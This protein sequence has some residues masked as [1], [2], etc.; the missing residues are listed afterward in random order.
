MRVLSSY[1]ILLLLGFVIFP[2]K[3][4]VADK[5]V[6][7]MVF[8]D[9][10]LSLD[11]RVQDLISRLSLEE[12]IAQMMN[13]TPEIKRLNIPAYNY[14]NEALHG[15]GRSGVATVFPQAIGLGATFDADL[16]LR[17]SSA[18]SDEARAMYN[19]AKAK[20][21]NLQYGGLTFWTPNINIFRDPRWGRGQETYGEDPFLTAKIGTA[22]VQGLQGD[23]PNYLKTAACAKHFAVHSGPEKVRHGFNAEATPKDLWETFLPAFQALVVDAKVE[24]VMC[25][26][27]STNGEPCCA[28]K[29]LIT[30]VLK[31]QWGF[32]GH[33]VTDCGAIQDFYTTKEKGG[34]GT[35]ETKAQAAALVLKSGV[36]L[37]CGDSF[38]ALGDAVKQGLLTE[39]DIDKELAVLLRTRF[40]LGL[41]DPMGSNPYDAI[42][43]TV[44][45]SSEHRALAKEVAQKSM[46]LLKN[47]GVLPLKNDL[48]K[49]FVTGPNASSIEVLLGNYY[50]INPDMVTILEGI[51]GAIQPESKLEYRLGAMLN[52]P[53]INPINYATGNAGNSDVTIVV[54]GVSSTLE[55]EEGD[56]IDSDSAGDRLYYDLPTNQIEYLRDLR[57]EAD[58]KPESKKPIV[59]VITGGSPINLAEVQ[60]LADAVLLVWYPGE[61]GGNA[62]A[63]ILFGKI[64]PSGKLPITFPKSLDQLPAFENYSMKGRT[65]R[66]MEVDPMYPFGFGLTYASFSYSDAK[67]SSKIISKKD[68]VTMSVK[69]TNTGKVKSDEVVQLYVSDLKASVVVPNFQLNNMKRITLKPGESKEVSF[70]LTSKAF[71]MVKNDGSKTIE[72]GDFKIYVG[73]SSPMK[74]SFELGAPKMAEAIVTVK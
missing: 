33:V 20:G 61:E 74:R 68:E 45:N 37:N 73:G 4:Q 10:S 63:D 28:N 59:A 46:V 1:F 42:S 9:T 19:V 18:I 25:A 11:K 48:P 53:S 54:L 41:F 62:V 56:S 35:L 55:G 17:V 5:K 2:C 24:S 36:G 43:Y 52:K 8:N 58:K 47:N 6:E 23:N 27:N 13:G 32:K 14:W 22:F 3:G 66:Y 67:I 57:K 40:K 71:E 34:H 65:Y 15:V 72:S 60:E 12:K 38:S 16:A 31:K 44:V 29:Y 39:K 7:S 64:S 50:G 49:Y 51:T 69:V 30:D 70:Q 26:Y 21:Y